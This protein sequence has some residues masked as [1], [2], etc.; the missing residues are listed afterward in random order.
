METCLRR[1]GEESNLDRGKNHAVFLLEAT[2][3]KLQKTD[4]ESVSIAAGSESKHPIMVYASEAALGAEPMQL[5]QALR[6][7]TMFFSLFS[8]RK[9][10]RAKT[11]HSRHLCV[12]TTRFS[13][14]S[15][16]WNNQDQLL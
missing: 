16:P 15:Y 3:M 13:R 10:H 1:S 12:P 11:H 4:A 6:V 9:S 2:N 7:S 14:M 5:S 8:A